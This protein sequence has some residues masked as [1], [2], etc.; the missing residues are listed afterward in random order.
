MTTT[1]ISWFTQQ[2]RSCGLDFSFVEYKGI[3]IRRARKETNVYRFRGHF[4]SNPIIYAEIWEDLQT[5]E[6]E[7]ARVPTKDLNIHFFL[8]AMHHLNCY[9]T[10]VERETMSDISHKWGCNWC[11]Y[12]IEKVQALKA[13]KITWPDDFGNDIWVLTVDDIH[14]W[15]QEP[16]HATW[17]LDS[18]YYSHKFAK[19]GINYELE[20][21]LV[22]S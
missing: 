17:S 7:E 2:I 10:E 16:G 14:C 5:T 3:R 22:E 20:M 6:V 21:S 4:G 13:Q 8:M 11:W 9:P 18:E 1:T 15:I 12:C 19:D